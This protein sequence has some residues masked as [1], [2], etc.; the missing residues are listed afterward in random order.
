MTSTSLVYWFITSWAQM[1]AAP[2]RQEEGTSNKGPCQKYHFPFIWKV[3][4][5]L[6]ASHSLLISLH[7]NVV[8]N[9]IFQRWPHHHIYPSP[10]VLF[11]MWWVL[12]QLR[13]HI[14][15]LRIWKGDLCDSF[16]Q[17]STAEVIICDFWGTIIKRIQLPSGGLSLRK[18]LEP[19][20]HDETTCEYSSW[21]CSKHKH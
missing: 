10:R 21:A 7:L 14:L 13:G 16:D 4:A 15:S 9:C 6:E 20:N 17:Q 5:S 18:L 8:A 11:T 12:L 1:I 2:S 3:K 19:R